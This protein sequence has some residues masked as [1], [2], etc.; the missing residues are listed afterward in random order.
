MRIDT[1]RVLPVVFLGVVVSALWACGGGGSD[2][3]N[4]ADSAANEGRLVLE[5]EVLTEVGAAAGASLRFPGVQVCALGMCG[6]TDAMGEYKFTANDIF[7]GG[8][9][10][11]TFNGPDTTAMVFVN[12]PESAKEVDSD[13]LRKDTDTVEAVLVKI[14]G[15]DDA[16][17]G[18][19]SFND[20]D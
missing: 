4:A 9:I 19:S 1:F 17:Q 13:F 10:Q 14:D 18:D 7:S 15:V 5:G 12:A 16:A 8:N 11:F 3:G 20:G 2:N 6:L